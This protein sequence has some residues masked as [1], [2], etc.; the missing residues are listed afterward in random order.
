MITAPDERD[1][2][3]WLVPTRLVRLETYRKFLASLR[4]FAPEIEAAVVYAS[5]SEAD[6]FA[7]QGCRADIVFVLEDFFSPEEVEAFLAK[8]SIINV[9]KLFAVKALFQQERV[10]RVIVTDD[11]VEIFQPLGLNRVLDYE[12]VY[13]FHKVSNEFLRKVIASPLA[14]LT[15]PGEKLRV[16]DFFVEGDFYGWFSDIPIYEKEH[17]ER[18][19]ERYGLRNT[20]DFSRLSFESFDWIMYAYS[21]FLD[22]EP[23]SFTNSLGRL[24]VM[25]HRGLKWAIGV[26]AVARC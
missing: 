9:K 26:D 3:V 7:Q 21:K 15:D 11:E 18:F 24:L 22:W 20:A 4:R 5:H 25:Q 19:F 12:P 13:S 2:V 6:A 8:R 14:L 1:R 17:I 10:S 16:H 23:Q